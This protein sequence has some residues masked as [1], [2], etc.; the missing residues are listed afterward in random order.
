MLENVLFSEEGT[1]NDLLSKKGVY[2]NMW[3]LQQ[4]SFR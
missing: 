4:E 2:A 3:N 1:H